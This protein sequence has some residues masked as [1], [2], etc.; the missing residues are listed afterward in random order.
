MPGSF[1]NK[2]KLSRRL[3]LHFLLI[4]LVHW[5]FPSLGATQQQLC[6]ELI[7]RWESISQPDF[8]ASKKPMIDEVSSGTKS[9][10]SKLVRQLLI[11][12]ESINTQKISSLINPKIYSSL[13][14]QMK[15]TYLIANLKQGFLQPRAGEEPLSF[16]EGVYLELHKISAPKPFAWGDVE[17]HF[18]YS[19]L[20]RNDYY[21]SAAWS[22]GEYWPDSASP[23]ISLGRVQYLIKSV[24]P[25]T[26]QNEVVF[27]NP[28]PLTSLKRIVVPTGAKKLLLEKLIKENIPSPVQMSWD[29]LIVEQKYNLIP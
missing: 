19:L 4:G 6:K 11:A 28:V 29:Q 27:V 21:I 22:H 10:D 8:I 12:D 26:E 16:H 15:S 18:E 13:Q 7:K 23:A 24:L 2:M 20:D 14:H 3:F 1:G 9:M 25:K 5:S 17:L